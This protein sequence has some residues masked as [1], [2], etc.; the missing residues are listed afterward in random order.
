MDFDKV[1]A[2]LTG[3]WPFLAVAIILAFI[4]EVIKGLILGKDK[5]EMRDNAFTRFYAKTMPLHPIVT[6]ALLGLVLS[7]TIPDVVLTGGVVSSIL[8]FA[9]SGALSSSIY[10]LLKSLRPH[11]AQALRNKIAS[12]AG[13]KSSDKAE[14][15]DSASEDEP[16]EP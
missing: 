10:N 6:G 15:T 14:S 1:I 7:T 3:H 5:S 11:V 4:G 13:S 9:L 2:I 8:Y 16:K 12:A